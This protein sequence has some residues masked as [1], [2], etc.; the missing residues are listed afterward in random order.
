MPQA[1]GGVS[2]GTGVLGVGS[3]LSSSCSGALTTC[4]LHSDFS[5]LSFLKGK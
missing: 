3:M 5:S 2:R 4:W 1:D